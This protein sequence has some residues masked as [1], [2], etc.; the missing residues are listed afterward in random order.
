MSRWRRWIK[1]RR[2]K[3]ARHCPLFF[4]TLPAFLL[5]PNC[6]FGGEIDP[7]QINEIY[8]KS[9]NIQLKKRVS[10]MA[11]LFNDQNLSWGAC[12]TRDIR[13][14]KNLYSF[15][16]IIALWQKGWHFKKSYQKMFNFENWFLCEF[17]SNTWFFWRG[18]SQH[19]KNWKTRKGIYKYQFKGV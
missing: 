14:K 10:L 4:S 16:H 3:F 1:K 18:L 11:S 19:P 8:N 7:T 17:S 13:I 9:N 12:K 15:W 5:S 6:Y 2:K